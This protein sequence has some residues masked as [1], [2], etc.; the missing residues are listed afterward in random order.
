MNVR[1]GFLTARTKYLL[2][3]IAQIRDSKINSRLRCV[4]TSLSQGK[5]QA[6][7]EDSNSGYNS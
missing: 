3:K 5:L 7:L 6:L 2:L 4:K 1:S